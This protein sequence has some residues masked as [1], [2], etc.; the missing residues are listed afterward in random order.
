[1]ND[2]TMTTAAAESLRKA[3][4]KPT[5]VALIGASD[6]V[7]KLTAR[8]MTFMKKHGSKARVYPVNPVRDTVMGEKAYASVQDMPKP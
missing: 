6:N 5:A 8:P 1:M 2:L 4:T 3:L 7:K